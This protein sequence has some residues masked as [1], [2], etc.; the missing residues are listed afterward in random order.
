MD[1]QKRA[2]AIKNFSSNVLE[3][4]AEKKLS[5]RELGNLANI[6]GHQIALYER[7]VCLPMKSSLLRLAKALAVTPQS[8]LTPVVERLHPNQVAPRRPRS[9]TLAHFAQQYQERTISFDVMTNILRASLMAPV[10]YTMLV[11]EVS[12]LVTRVGTELGVKFKMSDTRYKFHVVQSWGRT[13]RTGS[14]QAVISA[15]LEVFIPG[16]DKQHTRVLIT[17][18]TNHLNYLTN[19]VHRMRISI[20]SKEMAQVLLNDATLTEA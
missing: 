5:Q 3:L 9:N 6:S 2:E 12:S 13:E 1:S 10:Y 14:P 11:K 18:D 16:V 8:I 7:G 4:R 15:F 20:V 17:L 19:S